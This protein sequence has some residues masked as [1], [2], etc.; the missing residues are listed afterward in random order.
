[1]IVSGVLALAGVLGVITSDMRYRNIGIIGYV[2]VFWIVSVLLVI[3]FWRAEPL[4][5]S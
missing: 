4:N 1:M 2:G 5:G 3:V